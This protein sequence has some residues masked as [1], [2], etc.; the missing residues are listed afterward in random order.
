MTAKLLKRWQGPDGGLTTQRGNVQFVHDNTIINWS[1]EGYLGEHSSS[2]RVL[3]EASYASPR[4]N[5]YRAY[6]SPWTG[7]PTETPALKIYAYTSAT[8]IDQ[9]VSALYVSWNGAT[10]VSALNFYG[11]QSPDGFVFLGHVTKTGFETTF[12]AHCMQWGYAEAVAANGT[13]LGT[14]RVQQMI[15]PGNFKGHCI[16]ALQAGK[17]Y[18]KMAG[19]GSGQRPELNEY[20]PIMVL[21]GVVLLI[22]AA[23]TY[24]W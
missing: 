23:F 20:V 17:P 15:T 6:K 2:L 9:Y 13:I 1:E 24:L 10:E 7:S 12:V 19:T 14:S 21:A 3:L 11:S 5:K 8:A 18:P 4:F 22:C 16:L